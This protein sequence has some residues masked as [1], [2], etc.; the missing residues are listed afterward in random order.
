MKILIIGNYG[1]TN[2]G[3]ELI[4]LGLLTGIFDEFPEAEI[5]VLTATPRETEQFVSEYF[6]GKIIHGIPRLPYG[7]RSL[8]DFLRSR[9]FSKTRAAFRDTD[10]V[11]LGGGGLF[12]DDESFFAIP[13]WIMQTLPALWYKKPIVTYGLGIGPINTR[14]GKYLTNQLLKRTRFIGVRDESSRMEIQEMA[15]EKGISQ[16]IDPVFLLKEKLDALISRQ[17]NSHSARKPYIIL[18]LRDFP[19]W[20]ENLYQEFAQLL[21]EIIHK[22]G[23]NIVF[24]PFQT[25]EETD[26]RLMNKIIVHMQEKEHIFCPENLSLQEICSLIKGAVFT[27]GMRLHANLLSLVLGKPFLP[28]AYSQ[29]TRAFMES[30]F[31]ELSKYVISFPKMDSKQAFSL[32]AGFIQRLSYFEAVTSNLSEK[33]Y[34]TAKNDFRQLKLQVKR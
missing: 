29:K 8:R 2:L 15:Q 23:F 22:Y 31:P 4:L 21:D 13:L 18:S 16:T 28:I 10:I 33:L 24:I 12:A 9:L 6:Q 14:I 27:L 11:L 20:T 17:E 34:K 32:I 30:F 3:D 7:F 19:G 5:S 1:A 25:R 26:R